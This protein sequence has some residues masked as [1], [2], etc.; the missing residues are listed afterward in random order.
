MRKVMLKYLPNICFL[1][2]LLIRIQKLA[3]N[4]SIEPRNNRCH[5]VTGS[6][7]HKQDTNAP[8]KEAANS[9]FCVTVQ[10][11]NTRLTFQTL[12]K[13]TK[14]NRKIYSI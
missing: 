2:V 14:F 11:T 7:R 4:A 6:K 5:K 1:C 3:K 8:K 9:F 13:N 12:Y 10:E